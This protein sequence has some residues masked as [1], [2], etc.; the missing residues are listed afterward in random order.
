MEE[1]GLNGALGHSQP[2]TG[3]SGRINNESIMCHTCARP[4]GR[5]RGRKGRPRMTK[6][7]HHLGRH[8]KLPSGF[9]ASLSV[10]SNAS[11][12]DLEGKSSLARREAALFKDSKDDLIFLILHLR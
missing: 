10:G 3:T 6:Y 12:H 4:G 1:V 9:H 11:N 2:G 5:G 8:H 7:A